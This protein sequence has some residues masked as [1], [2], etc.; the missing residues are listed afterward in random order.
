VPTAAVALA[1]A[2]AAVDT[3]ATPAIPSIAWITGAATT[4]AAFAGATNTGHIITTVVTALTVR[5]TGT[6]ASGARTSH[7]FTSGIPAAIA[8]GPTTIAVG[9]GFLG[10]GIYAAGAFTN[11]GG[12]LVAVGTAARTVPVPADRIIIVA[13]GTALVRTGAGTVTLV[14]IIPGVAGAL[15]GVTGGAVGLGRV[16]RYVAAGGVTFARATLIAE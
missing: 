6:G 9:G 11:R 10:A 2:A 7:A 14:L 15:I 1:L 3:R 5:A 12:A 4:R 16:V 13:V 8:A